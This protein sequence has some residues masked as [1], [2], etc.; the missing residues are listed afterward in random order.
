MLE[1]HSIRIMKDKP[2]TNTI[3][4]FTVKMLWKKSQNSNMKHFLHSFDRVTKGTI[5]RMNVK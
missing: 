4:V 1:T 3:Y 5:F 2:V